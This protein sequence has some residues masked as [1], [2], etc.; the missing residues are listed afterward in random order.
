MS[1]QILIK[2]LF[3]MFG[4]PDATEQLSLLRLWLCENFILQVSQRKLK[5]RFQIL[6]ESLFS[7]KKNGLAFLMQ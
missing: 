1:F 2:P 3:S 6:I 4:L 5:M 7:V